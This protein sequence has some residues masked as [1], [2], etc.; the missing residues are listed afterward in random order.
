MA[1]R[2]VIWIGAG[3]V[4]GMVAALVGIG[5]MAGGHGIYLPAHIL[6]PWL[7]LILPTAAVPGSA[8]VVATLPP[9]PIYGALIAYKRIWAIPVVVLHIL[10]IAA[11]LLVRSEY[12]P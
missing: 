8:L 1:K 5:A 6:I 9:Y 2:S 7:M 10:A 12:L 4:I 11:S 3:A